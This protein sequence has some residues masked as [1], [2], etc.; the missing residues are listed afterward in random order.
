MITMPSTNSFW[1]TA[2]TTL[3]SKANVGKNG[4]KYIAIIIFPKPGITYIGKP[5]IAPEAS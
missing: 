3:I 4:Q 1:D 2:I 5:Q